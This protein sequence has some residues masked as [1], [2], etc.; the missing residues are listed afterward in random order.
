M[1][2]H[3]LLNGFILHNPWRNW[4]VGNR[5]LDKEKGGASPSFFGE[6][7]SMNIKNTPPIETFRGENRFLSNFYPSPICY[8]GDEYPNVEAAFQ[9][10][11]TD[12]PQERA[13][14][15]ELTNPVMAKRKGR[16]VTLRPNWEVVKLGVMK[17]LVHQKFTRHADLKAKLLSTG[18]AELVET[19]RGRRAWNNH[20]GQILMEVR[21]E[22]RSQ[23]VG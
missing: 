15:R 8:Q 9:A 2:T 3:G 14:I 7:P 10:A 22:I 21:S 23:E 18:D 12:S 16:K 17:E 1:F 4:I 20:L 11:K 6:H 5:W 13:K 19:I